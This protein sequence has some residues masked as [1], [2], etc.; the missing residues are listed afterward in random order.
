[1]QADCDAG[2]QHT[3]GRIEFGGHVGDKTTDIFA[4]THRRLEAVDHETPLVGDHAH[5][6]GQAELR[7]LI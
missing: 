6:V 7:V 2:I 5:Y 3:D 4:R 1:M